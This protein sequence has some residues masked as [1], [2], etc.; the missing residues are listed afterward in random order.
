[1][2]TEHLAPKLVDA[3]RDANCQVCRPAARR[4]SIHGLSLPSNLYIR[5]AT[6]PICERRKPTGDSESILYGFLTD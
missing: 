2:R 3:K 6:L 1:M 5:S 4:G